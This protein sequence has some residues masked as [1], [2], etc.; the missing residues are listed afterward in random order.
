MK[1]KSD[2]RKS[3]DMP[4]LSFASG[5]RGKYVSRLQEMNRTIT[6]AADVADI[7]PDSASANVALRKLASIIRSHENRDHEAKSA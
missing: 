5:S 7:F 1:K 4:E 2:A 3:S 6:L